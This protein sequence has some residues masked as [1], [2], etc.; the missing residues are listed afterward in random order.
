MARCSSSRRSTRSMPRSTRSPTSPD[1]LMES[2]RYKGLGDFSID[3]LVRSLTTDFGAPSLDI[4]VHSLANGP[5]VKKPLHRHQPR[6]IPRRPQRQLVLAREPG[7]TARTADA[8][9]RPFL[10]LSYMAGERVDARLRRRNVVGQGRARERYQDPRVRG[11]P[12]AW[13]PRQHHQRRS[14]TRRAPRARS[15]SSTRWSTTAPRTRR[16]PKR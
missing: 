14:A 1:D 9:G 6:G 15:A 11:R 10:S 2:K 8:P 13:L 7:A 5:E 12:K 4:V 16:F 3:G